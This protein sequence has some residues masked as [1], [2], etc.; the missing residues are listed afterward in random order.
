MGLLLGDRVH[1]KG[2]T[3][4]GVARL[5]RRMDALT[6]GHRQL[7]MKQLR[8]SRAEIRRHHRVEKLWK[9]GWALSDRTRVLMLSLIKE[10]GWLT[11]TELEAAL[12]ISQQAVSQHV[13]VLRRARLVNSRKK[14]RWRYYT[15]DRL[16]AKILPE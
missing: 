15:V 14:G 7:R 6:R 9:W 10:Y 3:V 11:A 5:K 13:R 8:A 16:V 2:A 1:D 12:G 4:K